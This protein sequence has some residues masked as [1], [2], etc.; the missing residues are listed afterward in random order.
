MRTQCKH[1]NRAH[2]GR[3][4]AWVRNIMMRL[5]LKLRI[6]VQ[7]ASSVLLAEAVCSLGMMSVWPS[8]K[9]PLPM[10]C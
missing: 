5:F 6:S 2:K 9:D 3:S 4:H 10:L 8:T 7:V 1:H